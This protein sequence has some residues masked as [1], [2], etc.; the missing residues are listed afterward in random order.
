MQAWAIDLRA[1]PP[2]RYTLVVDGAAVLDFYLGE[3]P[4][5]KLWAVVEIFAGGA[6]QVQH[7]PEA[8]QAIDAAG[9]AYTPTRTFTIALD[10]SRTFWRYYIFDREQGGAPDGEY[11]I[12]DKSRGGTSAGVTT[13]TASSSSGGTIRRRSMGV[14]SSCSNPSKR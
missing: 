10:S 5:K 3:A 2:G 8:C 11:E 4:V 13:S 9:H 12:V 7:I 14:P 6:N 1:Q